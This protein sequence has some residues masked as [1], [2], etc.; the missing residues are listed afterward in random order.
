MLS[1]F[2]LST[3]FIHWLGLLFCDILSLIFCDITP[4][5]TYVLYFYISLTHKNSVYD[6]VNYVYHVYQDLYCISHYLKKIHF[7]VLSFEFTDLALFRSN[8]DHN[9]SIMA[10]FSD[11]IDLIFL[12]VHPCSNVI[13]NLHLPYSHSV[14]QYSGHIYVLLH[15]LVP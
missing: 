13:T 15:L 2:D 8:M 12:I 1:S 6:Y 5:P 4:F 10:V 9:F 3:C 11:I 7:W 14:L